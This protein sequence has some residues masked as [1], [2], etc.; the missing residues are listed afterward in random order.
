[1]GNVFEKGCLESILDMHTFSAPD[2]AKALGFRQLL[3]A[4]GRTEFGIA[5]THK[6][7][8]FQNWCLP[9]L[10]REDDLQFCTSLHVA[11][12]GILWYDDIVAWL[13]GFD[14][15]E[16]IFMLTQKIFTMN[17]ASNFS[18]TLSKVFSQVA[19]LVLKMTLGFLKH[20]LWS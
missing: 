14:Q 2:A 8:V 19:C 15:D 12:T 3:L 13:E 5:R 10:T 7:W 16:N 18:L 6:E 11:N 1:M 17:G 20:R 4:E 9:I